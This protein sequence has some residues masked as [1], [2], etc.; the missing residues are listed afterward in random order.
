MCTTTLSTG[1]F[2]EVSLK[3][4]VVCWRKYASK[5]Y[6][7]KTLAKISW[8]ENHDNKPTNTKYNSM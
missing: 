7:A 4:D 3:F 5:I 6:E 8:A 2:F 1:N